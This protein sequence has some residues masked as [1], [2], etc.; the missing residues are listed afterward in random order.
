MFEPL[1]LGCG[2]LYSLGDSFLHLLTSFLCGVEYC[3]EGDDALGADDA[4]PLQLL[5]CEKTSVGINTN[6]NNKFFII[7][8]FV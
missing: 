2:L 4:P 5:T 6:K 8:S 1:L 7:L 3:I